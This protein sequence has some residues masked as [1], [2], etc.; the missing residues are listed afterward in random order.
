MKYICI[1]LVLVSCISFG[2]AQTAKEM[3]EA[4]ENAAHM[5]FKGIPINGSLSDFT[6]KMKQKGFSHLGTQDGTALFSGE[7]AGYKNCT[8]GAVSSK[9]TNVVSKVVVIFPEKDTWS[10]LYADYSNLKS[11][12]TR[13]YGEPTENVEKFDSY[14]EPDDDAD[15]MYEVEFDRCKFISVWE[16]EKGDIELTIDHQGVSSCYVRLSYWDKIN[17]EKVTNSAIDDL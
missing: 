11:M 16:T 6:V 9:N 5:T 13:K 4:Q 8:I 10:R 7:F 14:S 17:T 12:L 3:F 2:S 1:L 15:R